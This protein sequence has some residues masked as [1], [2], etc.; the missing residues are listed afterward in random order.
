MTI[1]L[2]CDHAGFELKEIL[3]QYLQEIPL[4][5]EDLGAYSTDSV[6]YPDFAKK[7]A[8]SVAG[9]PKSKGVLICGS[10]IGVSIAANRFKGIRAAL[11][12]VTED[13]KLARKHN[14]AN[15]LVLGGRITEN[16][17]AIDILKNFLNTSF[18]GGRHMKRVNK[19]DTETGFFEEPIETADPAIFAAIEQEKERQF[20]NI[21]LIASENI[22][23]KAVMDAQGSVLT[24][25]YAEGYPHKRYYG[26]CE[27]VDIAE[28]LAIERLTKLFGVKYANVQP[29]S[30][31][32]ANQAVFMSLLQPGD[33][34]LG[35][36][37]DAGGH[38]T[39]GSSV[40][41]SGKWFNAVQYGVSRETGQI[42]MDEVRKLAHEHKPKLIIT[43]CSAYPRTLDF[44]EFGKI[45]KEVG[46]YLLADVAHYSGLI[47]AGVYPSPV[48]HADVIT[49]TTHKILR[50][51][52]GGVIMTDSQE[53]IK[54]INSAIFPGL[55]GGPLMHVIAAKAVAFGEA[56]Q[57]DFK[58]YGANVVKNC[59]VLGD[60]LM[61]RGYEL[62]TG[63][64]ECHMLV[65]DLRKQGL[66]GKAAQ[67]SMEK[68]GLTCN[69]N[70][71]P[72]DTEKPFITSGIR[73][74]TAAGT[75][76]GFGVNEW[77]D[78]ANMIADVLDALQTGKNAEIE[79]QIF[80]KVKVLCDN[81]PIYNL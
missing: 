53:L 3:K 80:E 55:Q 2:A 65:V 43:G 77:T 45:A 41:Q 70:T 64:T 46:A 51:P 19:I 6:D 62:F 38:L 21:E 30:G 14:N 16:S 15:V 12:R 31:S 48:G 79:P 56:L 39:H 69:K 75:T 1:Y 32:Q 71:I 73:L 60:V 28:D 13:A 29:H 7:L 23:S 63:G 10:G 61:E 44:A 9:Q 5:F 25:K 17:L 81:F 74:G 47:A 35:M 78:I 4:E 42:D 20:Y 67:E 33:T 50:G 11:C 26:G 37:L 36:S 54:K 68:A 27:Y 24:N 72:F 22:V 57:D 40:N 34:I 66:T 58:T 18:E 59:K 52:R 49:S 76:R 8:K